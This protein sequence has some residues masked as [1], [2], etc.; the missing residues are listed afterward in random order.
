MCQH[1]YYLLPSHAKRYANR[2]FY[3]WENWEKMR[4][5]RHFTLEKGANV[6]WTLVPINVS[7]K[8]MTSKL[9]KYLF[10]ILIHLREVNVCVMVCL[11]SSTMKASSDCQ[12]S[13]TCLRGMDQQ[14]CVVNIHLGASVKFLHLYFRIYHIS[15]SKT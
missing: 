5:L 9:S 4:K 6:Y 1:C 3:A 10:F 13:K 12:M 8:S 15:P 2:A 11:Y 14:S 7:R